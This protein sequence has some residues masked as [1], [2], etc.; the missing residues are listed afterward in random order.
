M[1]HEITDRDGLVLTQKPAWHGLGT[2]LPEAPTV[3]EALVAAKLGWR[4]LKRPLTADVGGAPVEVPDHHA[5]VRED[6]SEVLGVVGGQYHVLQ[7]EDLAELIDG[8]A[9]AGRRVKVE[10]AGSLRAGRNVFFLAQSGAIEVGERDAVHLFHLF[11]NAHDGS[12]SFQVLPTSVRVVCRNTLTAAV[13]GA[14]RSIKV[15]HRA[16]LPERVRA[17]LQALQ[18][19]DAEQATFGDAVRQLAR[20]TL[21]ESDV[22]DFFLRLYQRE[23]ATI[24]TAAEAAADKAKA[25]ARDKAQRVVGA[26]LANMESELNP[27]APTAWKALNAVTQWAD[28][29]RTVRV[30]SNAG[31][32]RDAR[33][34]GNLFGDAADFKANAFDLALAL[35]R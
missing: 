30:T 12:A 20:V 1:A 11:A 21:D 33:T 15:P 22:R 14:K 9:A 27:G 23:Y 25:R 26:W 4:I 10:T 28:H 17:A 8:L 5:I 34:F 29:D 35:A 31:T 2:V 24:P 7:N 3:R 18:A 6:T 16:N 19:S 13:N 32:V